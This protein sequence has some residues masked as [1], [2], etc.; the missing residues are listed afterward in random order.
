MSDCLRFLD[1][2]DVEKPALRSMLHSDMLDNFPDGIWL[3]EFGPLADPDHLTNTLAA[4]LGVVEEP[5]GD[6][7]TAITDH[8]RGKTLLLIFDNCE[9]VIQASA[10]LAES[11]LQSCST[12]Y[13][14]A[15]SRELLGVNGERAIYVPSLSMPDRRHPPLPGQFAQFESIQ[16]FVDRAA[17]VIP[18]FTLNPDNEAAVAQI[19]QRLD[20]IPLAIELAAA[21]LRMLPVEQIATRLDDVF[22]LLTGGSRTALPRHQT[23]QALIDWSYDLLTEP[24]KAL[25]RRLAV[26]ARHW[27]LEAC[28][29][30]LCRRWS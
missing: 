27:T 23:L 14:L 9:H 19:C 6:L 28:E 26:F 13:I 5:D 21:R 11:L 10:E 15:T 3:I 12:V 20:G 7:I 16:L 30:N 8:L 1:T 29:V 24:E 4:V 17:N 22:R 25:F 18:E 2:V